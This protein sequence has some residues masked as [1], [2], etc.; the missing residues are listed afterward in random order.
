MNKNI[1]V[2]GGTGN[3]GHRI[4]KALLLRGAHVR[5]VVRAESDPAKVAELAS[6]GAE[7]VPVDMADVAALT[8]A[9]SGMACHR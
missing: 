1:L 5:A 3:L 2:A 7:V 4:T 8:Q 9:C 6:L